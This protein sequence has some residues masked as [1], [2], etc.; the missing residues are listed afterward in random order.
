MYGIYVQNKDQLT[1]GVE[2]LGKLGNEE[3]DWVAFEAASG[4]GIEVCTAHREREMLD[5]RH[6]LYMPSH[7]SSCSTNSCKVRCCV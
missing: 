3:P 5:S 4:I 7:P 2:Y 1:G 6:H